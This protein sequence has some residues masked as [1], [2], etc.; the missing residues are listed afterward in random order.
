MKEYWNVLY[1]DMYP[2]ITFKFDKI[3]PIEIISLVTES[4]EFE[5]SSLNKKDEFV[6]KCLLHVKWTKDG[7]KYFPLIDEEQNPH[8]PELL[9]NPTI[10]FDLFYAFRRDVI[11]PVFIESKTC[12]N[13]MQGK[14]DNNQTSNK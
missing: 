7:N 3:N 11:T 9:T 10:S 1:E 2:G 5:K 4:L 13:L 12:Q 8:L 6:K 14:K